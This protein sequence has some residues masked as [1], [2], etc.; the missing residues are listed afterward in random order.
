MVTAKELKG[1]EAK[2]I[3][4]DDGGHYFFGYYD[5]QPFD[6]TGRYHL[7]HRAPF[8]GKIPG[9]EDVCELGAI[10][11]QTGKFI[12]YAE[13]K[14]WNFQQ[15]SLLRWYR[16]DDHILF[17]V[18]EDGA[19]RCCILNIKTGEKKILPRAIAD[20]TK[21]GKWGVCIN[22]SRVWNFRAGYGYAGIVDP[23]FDDKAPAAD[24][25]FLM[26]M[27]TGENKQI[28]DFV[29][30]RDFAPKAPYS[31]GKLLVNHINFNP[32]GTRFCMLVR[33][34]RE[35]EE[36]WRSNLLTSDLE[37]NLHLM[38]LYSFQS[39]YN[40]KNDE[41]LLIYGGL[42]DEARY[43]GLYLFKDLT[44]KVSLLPDPNPER[45]FHCLYSPNRRYIIGDDYP[46][47]D[48]FR[49]IHLIDTEKA[50]DTIL[51][52]YF[53]GA[54]AAKNADHCDDARC[55]LHGRFDHTGRYFS[56]DSVHT[57]IRTVCMLDLS[58]LEGYEY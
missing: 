13:T 45:D 5:L 4:P 31:N 35:G 38:A 11:L 58:Q 42:R 56:F 27:E 19:Y 34:F 41:E 14:A 12:K 1:L 8:E 43:D 44:N 40:W 50:T 9:P 16:D 28:L 2:V 18:R 26:D 52:R 46:D 39:H 10:D 51:G 49:A 3:T 48:H 25:V 53:S 20:V 47:D 17:N 29:K 33:N 7:V 30:L 24:G 37:G 6:T 21:D 22:F 15:G 55:D 32:S 23:Y 57:G 36:L 54:T